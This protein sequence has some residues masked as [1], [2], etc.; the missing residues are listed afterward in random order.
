MQPD[1]LDELRPRVDQRDRD[2]VVEPQVVGGEDACISA[3]DHDDIGVLGHDCSFEILRLA[4]SSRSD[5]K[6]PGIVEL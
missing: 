4:L 1:P 5:L 3:T 2:V 6:T